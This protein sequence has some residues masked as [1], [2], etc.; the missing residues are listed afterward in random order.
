MM[1]LKKDVVLAVVVPP[2]G[3]RALVMFSPRAIWRTGDYSV[4][5]D[6]AS[7]TVAKTCPQTGSTPQALPFWHD[8]YRNISVNDRCATASGPTILIF[9][10]GRLPWNAQCVGPACRA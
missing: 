6:L 3:G 5:K 10:A 4:F 9:F 7:I 2:V 8:F 1:F